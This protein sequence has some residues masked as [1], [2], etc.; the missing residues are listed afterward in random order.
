MNL[1]ERILNELY[2]IMHR[3]EK[4]TLLNF[5]KGFPVTCKAFIVEIRDNSI[6]LKAEP[7]GS[8]CLHPDGM[9]WLLSSEPLEAIRGKVAAFDICSGRVELRELTYIDTHLGKRMS[10]R[11][12]PRNP[13]TVRIQGEGLEAKEKLADISIDG[14]GVYAASSDGEALK[15]NDSIRL[16]IELPIGEITLPGKIRNISPAGDK[17][18]FSIAFTENVPEKSVILRYIADRRMELS[19]EIQTLYERIYR[20]QCLKIS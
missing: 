18:R 9:T 12:A 1:N 7:P 16:T 17:V 5:Y 8:V 2:H 6:I 15:L 11:V 4:V 3:G 20:E 19:E 10:A 14:V 13:L